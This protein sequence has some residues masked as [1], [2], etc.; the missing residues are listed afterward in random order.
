MYHSIL[1]CI[2]SIDYSNNSNNIIKKS[3][4]NKNN[5]KNSKKNN[6]NSNNNLKLIYPNDTVGR[7]INVMD[8]NTYK[9]LNDIDYEY[10]VSVKFFHKTHKNHK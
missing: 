5:N 1:E 3:R 7:K 6:R 4:K 2:S 8:L 9:Y 10:L